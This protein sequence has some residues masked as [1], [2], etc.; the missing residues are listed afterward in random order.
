LT[1]LA[2]AAVVGL[3]VPLGTALFMQ[4]SAESARPLA[5]ATLEPAVVVAKRI[6]R[7]DVSQATLLPRA[8]L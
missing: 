4:A 7:T 6:A 8:P 1:H 2:L 3:G 5:S